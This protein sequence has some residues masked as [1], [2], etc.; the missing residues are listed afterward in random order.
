MKMNAIGLLEMKNI[1]KAAIDAVKPSALI[2]NRLKFSNN[3]LHI[4]DKQFEINDSIIKIDKN[5]YVVGIYVKMN[6]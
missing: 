2:W 4:D 3:H 6:C 5:C 1:F